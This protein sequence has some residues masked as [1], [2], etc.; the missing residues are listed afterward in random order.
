MSARRCRS[1]FRL[2]LLTA[3]RSFTME[4]TFYD[5]IGRIF[6]KKH[7]RDQC[8]DCCYD[9]RTMNR[10]VEEDAGIRKKRTPLEEC[11][12]M[13]AVSV[14]ALR[15]MDRMEPR[16]G[17]EMYQ[18]NREYLEK[19][20]KELEEFAAQGLNVEEAKCEAM[21]KED[22]EEKERRAL[23]QASSRQNPGQRVF[24]FGG[25]ETQQLYDDFVRGPSNEGYDL[26]S[27]AFCGEPST[28]KK[29]LCARCRA[30]AYCSRKCQKEHW[31]VHK[32]TC[33]KDSRT[34]DGENA[35]ASKSYLTWDQVEAHGGAPAKG[36]LEVRAILD[37]SMMRQVMSCKDRK[38]SIHRIAAYTN[39]RHIPEFRVGRVLRWK[40][41]RFKFF[42][43]GKQW[44]SS[45]RGGSGEYRSYQHLN[46]AKLAFCAN[47]S[48]HV[49]QYFDPVA[50]CTLV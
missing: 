12:E 22:D 6:C 13:W 20:G 31:K 32:K 39:S 28:H 41:P 1:M 42:M 49:V 34:G 36:T 14:T 4:E 24:E 18:M 44:R 5:D 3:D 38:G 45:G 47:S 21:K 37:E 15:G 46:E 16:P 23:M 27:C 29:N 2:Q 25:S 35:P 9:F 11:A 7:C 30:V 26:Y 19:Y 10:Q 40:N 43:D 48:V 50:L 33:N 17:P 8:H